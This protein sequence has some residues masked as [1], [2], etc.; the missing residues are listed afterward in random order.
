MPDTDPIPA[1][2]SAT[3]VVLLCALLAG[4]CAGNKPKSV[5][6]PVPAQRLEL[7]GYSFLPPEEKEWFVA[8]RGPDFIGLAK[9]GKYIGQT[10]TIQGVRVALPATPATLMLVNHVRGSELK[11]LPPPRF[12]VRSHEVVP[13]TVNGAACVMSQIE[14]EDREPAATT[15]PIVALLMETFSLTCRDAAQPGSGVQLSYT[16]RSYP[17][18]RD[19]GARARAEAVLG[20]LKLQQPAQR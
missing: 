4:G 10:L 9:A 6:L 11:S 7:N 8:E 15:G 16:H 2:T 13:I 20:S 17:E 12:R 14:V 18:D 5:E 1:R 19:A 3:A